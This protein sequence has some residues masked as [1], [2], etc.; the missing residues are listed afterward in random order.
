MMFQTMMMGEF[1]RL[2]LVDRFIQRP[3]EAMFWYNMT[4]REE[5]DE[6]T[7]VARTAQVLRLQWPL[8]RGKA[9]EEV[10][11][12]TY[13]TAPSNGVVPSTV[14]VGGESQSRLARDHPRFKGKAPQLLGGEVFIQATVKDGVHGIDAQQCF[15]HTNHVGNTVLQRIQTTEADVGGRLAN[16]EGTVRQIG[17]AVQTMIT[18]PQQAAPQYAP[19]Y[20]PSRGGAKKPNDGKC[21]Q[22]GGYGHVKANCWKVKGGDAETSRQDFQSVPQPSGTG[23]Q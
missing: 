18:R 14:L 23:K 10:N 13:S 6:Q 9:G 12:Y 1:D 11:D 2:L 5:F 19:S 3:E 20:A 17:S 16:L 15:D 4:I 7:K 21:F 8:L 22:C